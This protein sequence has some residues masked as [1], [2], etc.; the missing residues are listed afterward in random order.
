MTTYAPP[1]LA[2]RL[3]GGGHHVK[4]QVSEAGVV[5]LITSF[6]FKPVGPLLE[7]VL[8][9]ARRGVGVE[10]YHSHRE[11]RVSRYGRFKRWM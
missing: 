8:R 11:A 10:V 3:L 2:Q 4:I 5:A 7:A 9:A 6:Y 1:H